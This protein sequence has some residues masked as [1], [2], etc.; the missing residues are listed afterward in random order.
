[1]IKKRK[2]LIEIVTLV[3]GVLDISSA[4]HLPCL[5]PIR[6]KINLDAIRMAA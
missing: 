3:V 4:E 5:L 2:Q 1:M 6:C